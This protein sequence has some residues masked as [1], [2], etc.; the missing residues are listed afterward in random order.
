MARR[1]QE[2]SKPKTPS[3]NVEQEAFLG[4]LRAGD[5]LL[6]GVDELLRPAGLSHTQYNVLR[7][8]RGAGPPGLACRQVAERMLTRDPD[9]TRLLDRLEKRGLVRRARERRDRRVVS[10]RITAEG[11]RIL[12]ELDAP[13]A[14]LHRAQLKHMGKRN[15][16]SLLALL[17]RASAVKG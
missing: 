8:L 14:A 6:R 17:G 11:L 9:V 2:E 3:R 1:H 13:V 7:I 16:R 4:L 5:A 15:L 10:V 12:K